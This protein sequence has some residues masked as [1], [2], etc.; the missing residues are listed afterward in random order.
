[1]STVNC[2]HFNRFVN[3][4]VT[5]HSPHNIVELMSRYQSAHLNAKCHKVTLKVKLLIINVS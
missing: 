3:L 1:M 4:C 5:W 2:V